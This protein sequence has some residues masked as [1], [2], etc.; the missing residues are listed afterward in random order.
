MQ[1]KHN[2]DCW[3]ILPQIIVKLWNM[4]KKTQGQKKSRSRSKKKRKALKR[5][6]A[7]PD[8]VWELVLFNLFWTK[9]ALVPLELNT[10]PI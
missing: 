9:Q 7:A 5:L 10:G 1:G 6:V 4:G 2:L 8:P 3:Y